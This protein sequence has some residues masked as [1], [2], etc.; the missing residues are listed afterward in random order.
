MNPEMN[1]IT[2]M[3][4]QYRYDNNMNKN[5]QNKQNPNSGFNYYN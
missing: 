1:I 5:N 4:Y 3:R 2:N